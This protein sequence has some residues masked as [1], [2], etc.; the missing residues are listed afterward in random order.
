MAD[1]ILHNLNGNMRL[2][3]W[4]D[5]KNAAIINQLGLDRYKLLLSSPSSPSSIVL[6][7]SSL[8]FNFRQAIQTQFNQMDAHIDVVV[9]QKHHASNGL[10]VEVS[11]LPSRRVTLRRRAQ[12]SGTPNNQKSAYQMPTN[13]VAKSS[14]NSQARRHHFSLFLSFVC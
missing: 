13:L 6:I 3:N 11:D 10:Q 4:N 8:S 14:N 12:V 5:V 2:S 9:E 1:L 7:I